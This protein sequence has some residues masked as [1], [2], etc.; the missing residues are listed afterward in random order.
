MI[1]ISRHLLFYFSLVSC[2]IFNKSAEV[3]PTEDKSLIFPEGQYMQSVEAH[4]VTTSGSKDFNFNI[5]IKKE[6]EEIF[7]YGF[8]SFGISLFKMHQLN[9]NPVEIESS[10]SE[11]NKNKDFF[12]QTFSFVKEIFYL[13]KENSNLIQSHFNIRTKKIKA[14]IQLLKFDSQQIPR[15]IQIETSYPSRIIIQT[16]EY[17][18]KKDKVR[19]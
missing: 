12:M 15:L 13:Q 4:I 3:R 2:A 10:I 19:H 17:H 6:K 11:I 1:K 16:T 14:S 7:F 9:L 5:L 18:F 8:S